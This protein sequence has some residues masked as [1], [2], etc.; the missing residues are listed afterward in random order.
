MGVFNKT[1]VPLALVGYEMIIANLAR[2]IIVKYNPYR[3]LCTAPKSMERSRKNTAKLIITT[4][5]AF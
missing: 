5:I 2:G 1:I 3:Y 4:C